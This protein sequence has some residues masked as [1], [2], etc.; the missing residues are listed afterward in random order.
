MIEGCGGFVYAVGPDGSRHAA[1]AELGFGSG[2]IEE[3]IAQ[4]ARRCNKIPDDPS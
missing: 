2:G 1:H 4:T 3:V